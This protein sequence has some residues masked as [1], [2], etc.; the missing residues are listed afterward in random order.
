M[1]LI[2]A[3]CRTLIMLHKEVGFEGPLLTLGNQDVWADYEQLKSYFAGLG[4]PYEEAAAVPHTSRL[5]AQHPE[6]GN[7][8]HARTFFEMMGIKEYND[9]DKFE[10]DA[11]RILH[12]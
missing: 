11:P 1:G 7:F 10:D 4:C 2:P 6:A 9:I 3:I 8:V 5:L 12:D